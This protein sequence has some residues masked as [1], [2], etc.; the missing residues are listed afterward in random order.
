MPARVPARNRSFCYDPEVST[1][2]RDPATVELSWTA[3]RTADRSVD[4]L[5]AVLSEDELRRAE[6]FR[7]EAARRRFVTARVMLRRLLGR[8]LGLAPAGLIVTIGPRGKPELESLPAAPHF[9]LAHSG[10]LAVVAIASQEVGVDV[11]ELRPVPRA[12]RLAAR[13]FSESERR[14]LSALPAARRDRSFLDLWTC[15]EAYLKAAGT[16]IQLPVSR[17]EVDATKPALLSVPGDPGE[18][19]RWSLLRAEL[20]AP[21][22]CTVAIRGSGW[23]LEVSEFDW[24]LS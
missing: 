13:F 6:R 21:A 16:G 7:V 20:P 1:S 17:V 12:G 14:W 8:R 19:I 15:K 3:V 4:D 5:M 24:S 22:V 9:N 10:D 18:H 11:E 23:R 2:D